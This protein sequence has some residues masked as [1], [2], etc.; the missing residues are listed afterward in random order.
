MLPSSLRKNLY[1]PLATATIG[2]ASAGR[3]PIQVKP[4]ASAEESLREIVAFLA[5][6]EDIQRKSQADAD[7]DAV[8]SDRKNKRTEEVQLSSTIS[9]VVRP[10]CI[11][12]ARCLG[13]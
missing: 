3:P 13:H 7:R 6:E 4:T 10:L 9:V 11:H 5:R 8:I 1:S 12:L 2:I